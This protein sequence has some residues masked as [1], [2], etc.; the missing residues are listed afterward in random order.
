MFPQP[1]DVQSPE[2]TGTPILLR[3]PDWVRRLRSR[4]VL[5]VPR[6]NVPVVRT[7]TGPYSEPRAGA[8]PARPR[9]APRRVEVVGEV[10]GDLPERVEE[11]PPGEGVED[12]V[13]PELAYVP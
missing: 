4:R 13:L 10:L 2:V 9:P 7:T 6:R 5:L 11:E 3:S 12:H 8:D 1:P